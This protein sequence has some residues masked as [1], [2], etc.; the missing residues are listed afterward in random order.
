MPGIQYKI[1]VL[2]ALCTLLLFAALP[3]SAQDR[4]SH[5][6]QVH[7]HWHPTLEAIDAEL[8]R[9]RITLDEAIRQKIYAGYKPSLLQGRFKPEDSPPIRCMTPVLIEYEDAKSRLNPATIAEVEEL[10]APKIEGDEL[11]HLSPSGSFIFYYETSG[12]DAVPMEDADNSGV[13]DYV[14]QAAFAA[15]SSYRHQVETIGFKDFLRDEP[16][17]IEFRNTGF[18]GTTYSSG[19]TTTITV[20]SDFDGFPVNTHPDGDRLGALYVTIAHELKHAIQYATN[21]WDGEAGRFN[22]IEMDA[23]LMEEVVFD[24]VND[25]YNYIMDYDSQSDDW[26]RNKPHFR[27]IFSN[28]QNPTPGAYWHVSWML[29]FYEQHGMDLF[30]DIWDEFERE[31]D[32]PFLEAMNRALSVRNS[33]IDRE[34]LVNHLW[35]MSSGPFLSPPD[36]GFSDRENY[37]ESQF[38]ATMQALPDSLDNRFIEPLAATYV[39]VI[40]SNVLPGQP[41]F[42]LESSVRGVGLGVIGYFRDGSTDV[43]FTVDPGS[44][45]Q[46]V[47]TTWEWRELSDIRVAL[48]NTNQDSSA[49][50][51]LEVT[52]VLPDEDFLAQNYPNP[53]NPSTNIEFSLNE[54]K[55]VRLEVYDRIG[56]RVATLVNGRLEQGFHSVRFDGSGLASGVYFYRIITDQTALTKKMILVK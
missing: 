21:R 10:I 50:A 51:T 15:D 18:Y 5:Q 27:S 45:I 54:T 9:N 8:E 41:A 20:H 39:E 38:S 11:S 46:R 56:R 33:T 16:Y 26:N 1:K 42:Q 48:V 25:Y 19:S 31:R 52:S 28:P 37:P 29:Y 32:L 40:P 34:H 30:V 2:S 53:F 49:I 44:S 22:W 17:E 13:P 23:T 55:N 12:S 14:E 35:H 3:L 6:L 4:V 7:N 43:Q 47:Q 36:F 24:D